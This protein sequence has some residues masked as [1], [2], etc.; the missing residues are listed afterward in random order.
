MK[1]QNCKPLSAFGGINFVFEYLEKNNYGNLFNNILPDFK[2]QS[3]YQWS[4][5]IN[6]LL[7][8]YMCGG[9]CI[10]D[11]GTHLKDHFINNPF[12]NIPSPDTVLRR[13]SELSEDNL[14]C[15]TK[16]GKVDHT[17]NTN[18]ILEQTNISLLKKLGVFDADE[19]TLDYD[20]TIIFNEKSDSKM[21]YKRNYGYQPGVCTINEHHIL[22]IE[23]R[24]GNSDAKSF[25]SDT[26]KRLFKLLESNNIKSI[27]HFRA[28][29]ASYQYDVI[30]LLDKE[31]SNFYIGC[32]NSYIEK[33]FSE[34]TEWQ[35]INDS[36]DEPIEIG[37]INIVPFQQQAKK[38]GKVAKQYRLVV[39][40][41]PKKDGQ[42]DIF[43]QDA[44]QYRAILTNNNDYKAT[45]IALFYNHRGNME[46]QFDIM[47][48][49]F[50]WNNMPFSKL[51]QN[52]VFL[53]FT[54]MCRNLYEKIIHY[55]SMKTR[56]LKPTYRIK[57]FLFRFII[58][59]AKWVMRARQPHLNLYGQV[60]FST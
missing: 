45:E 51:N 40:R 35:T 47:K 41:K 12:I 4:D 50:G 57:K 20:N 38:Q 49:D 5:I 54:A 19:L 24:N 18:Q 43:T 59:P 26:L 42:Y 34:I 30:D 31:V 22:Y 21:T 53:Y 56:T 15:R 11:L 10:E 28:D 39:K 60:S 37:E 29:A 13:L 8:I 9:D 33:Y 6:S 7:S 55:F 48:N 27:N 16:K 23:N 36:C 52:T 17:Y 44:Y 2:K 1:V 3:K 32:R 58:I 25:Q 14:S 46:K